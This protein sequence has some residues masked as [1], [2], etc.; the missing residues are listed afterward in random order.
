MTDEHNEVWSQEAIESVTGKE[1][2]LVVY[3]DG[4][5]YLVGNAELR[6]TPDGLVAHV[7]IQ[8]ASVVPESATALDKGLIT[9]SLRANPYEPAIYG[10]GLSDEGRRMIDEVDR[11]ARAYGF[12]IGRGHPLTRYIPATSM[13][14][15]FLDPRWRDR[16]REQ[17]PKNHQI[18]SFGD[19]NSDD[20]WCDIYGYATPPDHTCSV[21]RCYNPV[22]DGQKLQGTVEDRIAKIDAGE[23]AMNKLAVLMRIDCD[24][25]TCKY[26]EPHRHGFACDKTCVICHG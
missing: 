20:E 17:G 13:A 26:Q 5:R 11:N 23:E 22:W 21:G 18:P 25:D 10:M 4:T 8:D 2:P 7:E 12:E 9:P 15:P 6:S 19:P 24:S 1:V 3:R 16:I 14:N